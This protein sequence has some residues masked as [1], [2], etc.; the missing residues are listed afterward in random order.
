MSLP[1]ATKKVYAVKLLHLIWRK[2]YNL[3]K[4]TIT[5]GVKQIKLPD[6]MRQSHAGVEEVT[7]S[8]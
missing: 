6:S 5:P 7:L 8:C 1:N 2:C 4:I 3:F